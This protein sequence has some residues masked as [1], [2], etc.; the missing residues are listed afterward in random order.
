MPG[1][2]TASPAAEQQPAEEVVESRQL[3]ITDLDG[4]H[5]QLLVRAITRV[6]STPLAEI[7]YAQIIDGLPI[8]DVAYESRDQPYDGHP[9]EHAHEELCPGMLEKAREFRDGF[10]P[11]ILTFNSEVR[12]SEHFQVMRLASCS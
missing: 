2:P 10:Q 3:S 8:A 7:T 9:M 6:L 11:E 1:Q 12:R 4:E 5:R